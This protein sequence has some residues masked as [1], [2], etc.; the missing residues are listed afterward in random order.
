ML[1]LIQIILA[2]IIIGLILLQ[3][4]GAEGGALFG[5]QTQ[6]FLKKRGLERNLY[7]FTWILISAFVFVSLLKIIK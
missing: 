5:S 3:Q 7:Y 2:V 4:R 1:S 6:V